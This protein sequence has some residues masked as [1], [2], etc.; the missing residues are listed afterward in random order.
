MRIIVLPRAEADISEIAFFI[1]DDSLEAAM[2]FID[3]ARDAIE[4][5]SKFPDAGSDHLFSSESL[6]GTKSWPI[7]GFDKWLVFYQMRSDELL[8]IR[9]LHG[10]RDLNNL[11]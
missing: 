7:R 1:A 11:L 8:V 3:Q 2:R 5:L 4:F 10:A 6:K 9:V